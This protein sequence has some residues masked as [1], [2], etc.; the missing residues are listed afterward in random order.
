MSVSEKLQLLQE[1]YSNGKEFGLILDKLLD[2]TLSE[3]RLRL[4]RY[5]QEL[6]EFE[7]RF[8]MDSVQLYQQFQ[9]GAAGDAIEYFEW[10]GLYELKQDLLQKIQKLERVQ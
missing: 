7:Q 3:Y 8:G 4:A 1:T 5:D 2:S 9:H 6:H 10:T